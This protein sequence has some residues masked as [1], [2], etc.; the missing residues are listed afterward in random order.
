MPRVI[1]NGAIS[2]GLVHV[3]VALVPASGEGGIDFDWLDQRTMDPVGYK[4]VNK[5]TGREIESRH[6]V[7]G[8]KV[9][10]E[11]YVV[12]GD[13]EIRAAYP[14][15]TQ[16][17]EIE[18]FVKPEQ[19]PFV[20]LEKPYYLE[21]LNKGEKVYT[22]LREAMHA[23]GVVGV[24]RVVL[25]AKEHLAV[26]V[27][28]GPALLLDTLRWA[29]DVRPWTELKL[30]PEGRGALRDA[31]LKMAGQLIEDMTEDWQGERYTD[32]FTE[33][34]QALVDRRAEA[35]DTAEVQPLEGDGTPAPTNVVDLTE[36]LKQSLGRKAPAKKTPRK[37]A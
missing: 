25:H 3:P 17:I 34:V 6:V 8:V 30:P 11:R 36:L 19:V 15:R 31:E 4:R 16:T 37:R 5:R 29:S 1:W 9:G 33:A 27:A 23:A 32:R 2:F 26:L 14:K 20:M 18:A 24:A 28:A 7:R 35:G 13:D 12:L 10:P 22:L 21:P